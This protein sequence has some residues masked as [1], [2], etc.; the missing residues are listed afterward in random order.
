MYYINPLIFSFL[1]KLNKIKILLVDIN[2]KI[3]NLKI[4][5]TI[6]I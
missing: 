1:K 6:K 5:N 2:N 3:K 4:K